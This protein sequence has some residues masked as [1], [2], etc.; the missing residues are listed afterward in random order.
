VGVEHKVW[1]LERCLFEQFPESNKE[2]WD[3]V[4]V[5]V[6]DK[7]DDVTGVAVALDPSCEAVDETVEHG[8]NV[9]LTHHP[10]LLRPSRVMLDNAVRSW[11]PG[12][13]ASL[14]I[15]Q[16]VENSI[17]RRAIVSGVSLIAMH[18]NFD[19]SENTQHILPDALGLTL[20]NPVEQTDQ[21]GSVGEGGRSFGAAQFCSTQPMALRDLARRC[22]RVFGVTPRVWGDPDKNIEFVCTCPGSGGSLVGA[23]ARVGA[24]C[25]VCGELHYHTARAARLA[26]MAIIELGHDVSENMFTDELRLVVIDLGYAP[27]RVVKLRTP[28]NWWTL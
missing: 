5:L 16:I 14:S 18:T 20:L 17:V 4:G 9:L 13:S 11:A 25:F 28:V 12:S 1:Y 2:D 7:Q 21:M 3:N 26:G 24:D 10:V 8:C 6:G 19:Y 22:R 15:E 27:D 23:A